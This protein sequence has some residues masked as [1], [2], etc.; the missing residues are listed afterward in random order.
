MNNHNFKP[1]TKNKPE[2]IAAREKIKAKIKAQYKTQRSF[3]EACKEKGYV[4]SESGLSHILSGRR[5]LHKPKEEFF[6]NILD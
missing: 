3:L 6:N 5:T 2:L 4:I 1:A